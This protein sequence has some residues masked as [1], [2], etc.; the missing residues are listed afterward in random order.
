MGGLRFISWVSESLL[1]LS[2]G[3]GI[4]SSAT[5]RNRSSALQTRL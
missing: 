1:V 5:K 2:Q 3:E 4:E